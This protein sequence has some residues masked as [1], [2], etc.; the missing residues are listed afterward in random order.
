MCPTFFHFL[1]VAV[2]TKVDSAPHVLFNFYL[3]GRPPEASGGWRN[4]WFQGGNHTTMV[5]QPEVNAIL[6]EA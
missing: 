2:L 6:I 4:H 5:V 1:G 3:D